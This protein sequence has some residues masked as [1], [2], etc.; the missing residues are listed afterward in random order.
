MDESF[1]LVSSSV[2]SETSEGARK[3]GSEMRVLFVVE[4]F[5]ESINA[6]LRKNY[7]VIKLIRQGSVF[8]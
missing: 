1:V 8:V 5:T 6:R 7:A 4:N 2:R 3:I